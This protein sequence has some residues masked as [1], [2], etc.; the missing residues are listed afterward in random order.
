VGWTLNPR[1]RAL[2]VLNA[3]QVAHLLAPVVRAV[4]IKAHHNHPTVTEVPYSSLTSRDLSLINS[5]KDKL[6]LN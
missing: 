3:V 2:R 1:S 5:F 6:K 4:G